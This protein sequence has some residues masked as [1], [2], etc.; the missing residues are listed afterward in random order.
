MKIINKSA[1]LLCFQTGK[2]RVDVLPGVVTVDERLDALKGKDKIFD[3]Y[4][5]EGIIKE[6]TAEDEGEKKTPKE[7]LVDR[8]EELGIDTTDMTKADLTLAIKEAEED[9]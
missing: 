2:G 4:L 5:K 9:L 6:V 1:R 3:H 7:I 8:A